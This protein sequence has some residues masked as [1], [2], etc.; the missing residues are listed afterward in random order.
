[1]RGALNLVP[2]A[3][4]SPYGSRTP[5]GLAVFLRVRPGLFEGA[6]AMDPE[7]HH[8][9]EKAPDSGESGHGMEHEMTDHP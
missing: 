2:G 7:M 9:H 6:H 4:E 5:V 8:G 1:V 3:L